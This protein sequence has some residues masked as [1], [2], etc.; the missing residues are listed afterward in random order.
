MT[1]TQGV[2]IGEYVPPILVA[3]VEVDIH[4]DF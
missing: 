2:S 1:V 3:P 4:G